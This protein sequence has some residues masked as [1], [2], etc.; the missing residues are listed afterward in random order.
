MTIL[1]L[2]IGSV[3]IRAVSA[4]LNSDNELKITGIG[5]APSEGIKKGVITN[6]ELASKSIKQ[7]CEQASLISGAQCDKVV[8]SVSGAYVKS[9]DSVGV[10]TIS[11]S[12]SDKNEKNNAN[13][14]NIGINQISRAIK[15][16]M[17]NATIPPNYEKLHVLPYNFKVEEQN[18][19]EDPLGMCGSRLEVSTHIILVQVGTLA[20]LKKVIENAGIAVDNIVLSG[21]ASSIATLNKDEKELGAVLID[22]GGATCNMV[23]HSGNSIR[24]NEFLSVGS[25]NITTDLS[26][27]LHTPMVNAENVKLK[28]RDLKLQ[29]SDIIELPVLANEQSMHEVSLNV[30]EKVIYAR[31]EETLMIL[32]KMLEKTN[33]KNLASAGVVLTG[34]MTKLDGIY[35][36]ACAVFN[37]MPVRMAKPREL[38]GLVEVLRDPE[39]SCAIGLCM[40]GAGHFTPYEI[41]SNG[42][43]RYKGEFDASLNNAKSSK[44]DISNFEYENNNNDFSKFTKDN[45]KNENEIKNIKEDKSGILSSA[46]KGHPDIGLP[47]EEMELNIFAK[48]WQKLGQIF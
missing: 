43:M 16:A 37:N 12:K 22:M 21:Y 4:E 8:V 44:F 11:N 19:I 38:S 23:I 1:G 9:V 29:G 42:N 28:Y 20:N 15:T 30:I 5:K 10:I 3:H 41:D 27:A 47:K 40:Y 39:N 14:S 33:L 31:A 32:A 34:G 6:I 7:A 17:Y 45:D 18:D 48:I 46:K 36:L 25:V 35:E 2:D 26:V 24:S 13:G